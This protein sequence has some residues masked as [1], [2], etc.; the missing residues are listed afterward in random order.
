[1]IAGTQAFA[2]GRD[3][4][5]SRTIAAIVLVGIIAAAAAVVIYKKKTAA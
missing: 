4:A 5:K 2:T 1:M 3:S